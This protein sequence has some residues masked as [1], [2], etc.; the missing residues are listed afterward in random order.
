M[1][2]EKNLPSRRGFLGRCLTPSIVPCLV[3][4]FSLKRLALS[5]FQGIPSGNHFHAFTYLDVPQDLAFWHC[6][7][8]DLDADIL[9]SRWQDSIASF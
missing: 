1:H 3:D 5:V 2:P 7:F 8:H 6:Y 4:S 9:F